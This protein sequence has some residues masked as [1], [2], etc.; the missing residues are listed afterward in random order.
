MAECNSTV[1]TKR[2]GPLGSTELPFPVFVNTTLITS[3]TPNLF[4][5]RFTFSRF[6]RLVILFVILIPVPEISLCIV[7]L[8]NSVDLLILIKGLVFTL[9]VRVDRLS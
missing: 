8:P 6:L 2:V 4:L 5:K 7:G 1:K 3:H 9:S